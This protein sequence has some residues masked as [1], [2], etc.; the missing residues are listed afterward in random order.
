MFAPDAPDVVAYAVHVARVLAA[1]I[2]DRNKSQVALDAGIDRSTLYDILAGRTWTDLITLAAL[3]RALGVPLWP[4]DP[5]A[6]E[7]TER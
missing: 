4:S 7:R 2:S 1:A 5:P 3:E 6:L